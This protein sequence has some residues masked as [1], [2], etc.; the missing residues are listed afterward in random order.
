MRSFIL[1]FLLPLTAVAQAT[2]ISAP[3]AAAPAA[4]PPVHMIVARASGEPPG[5]GIIASLATAL[6]QQIPGST[7]EA[8]VYP[9][10]IPYSGSIP[11]GVTA[12]KA[13]IAKYTQACPT[14]KVIILGYSQGAAVLTDTLCGGGGGDVG[15]TTP[16]VTL[17]EGKLIKAAIG[18]GDPRFFPGTPYN[19]GTNHDKGG[20]CSSLLIPK[21]TTVTKIVLV[22]IIM[23]NVAL[24]CYERS[25]CCSMS[26]LG[27]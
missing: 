23:T 20:V 11:I 6:K 15:P 16:G 14:G 27:L 18:M 8:L 26:Y 13:A 22:S 25:E 17:E 2:L 3:P 1:S 7:S 24:G 9:A 12:M 10:K 4:C 19:A 5:E 21:R